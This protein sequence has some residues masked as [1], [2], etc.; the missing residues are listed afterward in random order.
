MI[1]WA[2]KYLLIITTAFAAFFITLAQVFR[3]GKKVEQH[4]QTEKI[5]KTAKTRLEIEDEINKKHDDDVRAA[6]SNWVRKK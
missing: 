1:W 6:L 2:K 3:L 4:K 5:L